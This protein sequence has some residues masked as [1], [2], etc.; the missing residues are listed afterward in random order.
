MRLENGCI[1]KKQTDQ[2]KAPIKKID[3]FKAHI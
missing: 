3:A 1:A 2:K